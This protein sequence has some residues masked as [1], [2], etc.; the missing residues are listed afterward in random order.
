ML[1]GVI[2]L[3]IVAF[4]Y[5]GKVVNK[6]VACII[7]Y[8]FFFAAE[9]A[10]AAVLALSNVEISVY[11]HNGDMYS[12]I[13]LAAVQWIIYE[14]VISFKNINS[15]V[16][17]PRVVN[18]IIIVIDAIIFALETAIFSQDSNS[19]SI[20]ILSVICMLLVIFLVVYLYDIISISY[21]KRMEA[22][23]IE[24][25]KNYYLKQTEL[26]QARDE[27]LRD[28][29]HDINNHLY[30]IGSMIGSEN[31]E[32]K[33]Y[34]ENLTEK[35]ITTKM[36][37]N[38]GN[39]AIDSVINYELSKAEKQDIKTNLNIVVPSG[40]Q[41]DVENLVT[42]FGNLLDNAIEAADKCTDEKYIDL[43]VR[44]KRGAM[45][46]DIKNSYDGVIVK[47]KN[48]IVTKKQNKNLH[49]IGLK[50]VEAA[51]NNYNGTMKLDFNEK[52]F[53]VSIMLYI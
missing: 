49:G 39:V 52:E 34:I 19:E 27:Q 42:I 4:G 15:K 9:A 14:I 45:F 1:C 36:Y 29:R 8:F 21:A 13:V 51:V 22:D 32:A 20:K 7:T 5:G 44:Y 53:K 30:V 40:I 3:F 10:V 33:K 12:F 35:I 48:R 28:F 6:L 24:R 50:S 37:S 43:K 38:T 25:E 17:V 18:I 16:E 46:I 41:N 23:S 11:G 31:E 2:T 47:R 26:L